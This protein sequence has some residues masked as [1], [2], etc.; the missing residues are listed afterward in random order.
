MQ[1]CWSPAVFTLLFLLFGVAA[2]GSASAGHDGVRALG[3]TDHSFH[4]GVN[5]N[6][7]QNPHTDC[8]L[9]CGNQLKC[10]V[11]RERYSDKLNVHGLTKF[12]YASIAYN[13]ATIG[14]DLAA[15]RLG[16]PSEIYSYPFRQA[17]LLCTAR[18]RL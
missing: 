17:V 15:P 10:E 1:H 8:E 9:L 12:E 7:P 4:A 6:E 13:S 5:D 2:G 14:D 16:V 3:L 18:L 11:R